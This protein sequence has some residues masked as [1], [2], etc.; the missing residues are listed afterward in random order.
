MKCS[1]CLDEFRDPRIL[2]CFHSFCKE[3][4]QGYINNS[5]T[6]RNHHDSVKFACPVCRSEIEL[7]QRGVDGLQKNFYLPDTAESTNEASHLFCPDHNKEDLRFFCRDCE[8]AIC[9]DCKVVS[10]TMHATDMVDTVAD[11]MRQ[12]LKTLLDETEAELDEKDK[13]LLESV[14]ND[15]SVFES[16]DFM[17]IRKEIEQDV[18]ELYM[19]VVDK[20]NLHYLSRQNILSLL[21]EEGCSNNGGYSY[22]RYMLSRYERALSWAVENKQSHVIMKIYKDLF[23]SDHKI[24]KMKEMSLF[25]Q[26]RLKANPPKMIVFTQKLKEAYEELSG[27]IKDLLNE[28]RDGDAMKSPME[29]STLRLNPPR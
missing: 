16:P 14:K 2:S 28:F 11:E 26:C 24:N 8:V 25:V 7:P 15:I 5:D 21:E 10:H 12:K 13:N 18:T 17:R 29:S 22:G 19:D 23:D 6:V 9:R 20:F 4:L 27:K 1:L 3:C